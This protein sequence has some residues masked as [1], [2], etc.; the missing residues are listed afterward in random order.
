[1][2]VIKQSRSVHC[3]TP[4]KGMEAQ[5]SKPVSMKKSTLFEGQVPIEEQV[6]KPLSMKKSTQSAGQALR[7]RFLNLLT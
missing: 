7:N 4:S 2:L 5:V 6:S 3:S 1:M